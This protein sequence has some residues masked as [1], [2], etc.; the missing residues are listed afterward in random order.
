MDLRLMCDGGGSLADINKY[1]LKEFRAHWECLENNN[2]R[3][4]HCRAQEK[5]YNKC[6]FD[7][8]VR[9]HTYRHTLSIPA[10]NYIET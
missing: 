10:D 9:K 6:V 1:C 8:L 4:F 2:H 5:P 3:L 7:N